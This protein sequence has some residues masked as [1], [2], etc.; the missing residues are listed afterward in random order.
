MRIPRN[1]PHPPG[2]GP[3]ESGPAGQSE[4]PEPEP[5]VL[6]RAV[7]RAMA[8]DL[9]VAATEMVCY[10]KHQHIINIPRDPIPL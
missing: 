6:E 1:I 10:G 8:D 2:P 4:P 5:A 9:V 3:A 7:P